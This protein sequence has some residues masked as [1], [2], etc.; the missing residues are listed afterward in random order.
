MS[1]P[2]DVINALAVPDFCTKHEQFWQM[3][4]FLFTEYNGSLV[5]TQLPPDTFRTMSVQLHTLI[6]SIE[7]FEELEFRA[8]L[9]YQSYFACVTKIRGHNTLQQ[10]LYI[11]SPEVLQALH[12]VY[13]LLLRLR[14][15]TL[16]LFG[17][18]K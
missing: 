4:Q 3:L 2:A 6:E 9:I 15:P 13:R 7:E 17:H 5:W 18:V 1:S 8:E 11:E 10:T 16:P 12:N 14:V